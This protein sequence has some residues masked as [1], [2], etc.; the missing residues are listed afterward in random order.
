MIGEDYFEL[1][2]RASGEQ[3]EIY[4]AQLADLGFE[5]FVEE[6]G[7]LKGY[8]EASD[9][10]PAT[11]MLA[12]LKANPA[13]FVAYQKI[14]GQNWNKS[15]ED[16]FEPVQIGNRLY[17]RAEHHAAKP[18]VEIELLI[19]PKMSFGT[20]HHATTASM[21]RLM[22]DLEMKGKFV[23]DAGCGTGILAI[24]AEKLGA[25]ACYGFDHESWTIENAKENGAMNGC[26]ACRFE[27]LDLEDAFDL[28]PSQI[29]LANITRN[30]VTGYMQLMTNNLADGGHFLCSGF[31]PDDVEV[32]AGKAQ[33]LGL[34]LQKQESEGNWVAL[35]FRK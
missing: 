26:R 22:L 31:G 17:I 24:L 2:L 5:S 3:A 30:L 10:E 35:Q 16:N 8:I 9:T 21:A 23:M 19:Q 7:L 32:V 14:E 1:C 29:V 27:E 11:E 4:I 13:I 6:D 12:E 33:D 15:W 25:K 34:V 20:G 18:D 28:P